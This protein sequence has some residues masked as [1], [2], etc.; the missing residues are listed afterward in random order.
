[1]LRTIHTNF[2]LPVY[3]TATYTAQHR[4]HDI[5][6]TILRCACIVSVTTNNQQ[7]QPFATGAIISF[8]AVAGTTVSNKLV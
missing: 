8:S 5:D 6:R 1:M 7:C 2:K 3:S 4:H